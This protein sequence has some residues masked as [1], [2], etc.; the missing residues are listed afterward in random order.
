M[1]VFTA[2][3]PVVVVGSLGVYYIYKEEHER[4]QQ[5]VMEAT[6]ALAS[7][8]EREL[9]RKEAIVRTLSGSP[10]ITRGDLKGFHEYARDVAQTDETVLALIDLTRQQVVNTR[11]A[12]G[13]PLPRSSI[14]SKREAAGPLATVVSDLYMAP[15]GRRHSF[16]VE[17]PVV[18]DGK[19]LYHL[20]MGSFASTLQRLVD[21]QKLPSGWIGTII[22][23][24][25]TIVARSINAAER[26]GKPVTQDMMEQLAQRQ[27]GAFWTVS[28][29]GVPVLA[30][31][32][33]SQLYGWG[34]IIGVPSTQITS[35]AQAAGLFAGGSLMVMLLA[36]YAATRVGRKIADPVHALATAS[37]ALGRGE[38]VR[39][40]PTG[41]V[42]A[43]LAL[44]AL[45]ASSDKLRASNDVLNAK[46]AEA[47]AG[48][49]KAQRA[50]IQS[51]R[52]E[53]IGQLTGG[54]AHDFNN[55]LMV[56]SSNAHLLGVRHGVHHTEEL[57]RIHRA[58]TSGSKLTRQLLA[59]ARRQPLSSEVVDVSQLLR[60]TVDLVAPTLFK[61]VQLELDAAQEGLYVRVDSSE[62]ELALINLAM[63][64]RDAMPA[65]G[66]LRLSARAGADD[67]TVLVQVED[68]GIGMPPEVLRR[69]FEPFFTTKPV[70][71]GTGLGLSQV[72][73]CVTQVGGT[74]EID[75]EVGHGTV[76]TLT[77]PRSS[78]P[79]DVPSVAG[80]LPL[81]TDESGEVLIVEDNPDVAVATS[82]ILEHAG[83]TVT[84]VES[85]DRALDILATRPW[86]ALLS[87]IR[88][89]GS[90]DGLGLARWVTA[91]MPDLPVVL[92][93]GYSD[94]HAEAMRLGLHVLAKPFAPDELVRELASAAARKRR[95]AAE[96]S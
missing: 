18:R 54:V 76:I 11:R 8:V 67:T 45:E 12:F 86:A 42:E 37:E 61:N 1:L 83:F 51:Q 96:P 87:D 21:A 56:V 41:L 92:M 17:V 26:V 64:A 44:K 68:S 24:Q 29:D 40:E 66:T 32:S 47:L 14:T 70:G 33:R 95:T 62:L 80:A 58:V 35:P 79:L 75:S 57:T 6:R 77:L 43:D 10:T 82:D 59:F 15:I 25:G 4:F 30:S 5:S 34:F 73:G 19:L 50:I 22:D 9:A 69:A 60:D 53:A 48:A 88:M 2:L 85:A 52:L 81:L 89:P 74:V 65:G 28:T 91:R 71:H 39:H 36:L 46:V 13:E 84:R 20:A 7:V 90:V 72:Y 16:A 63:N 31:F 55:L 38:A 93:T 27:E 49:E 23:S 78:D 94:D 3:A